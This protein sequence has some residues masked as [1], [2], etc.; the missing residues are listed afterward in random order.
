[1]VRDP[2]YDILFEP[3]KI[4]PVTARNRFYQVPHCNG[5]GRAYPSSMAAMR[6]TK[7]EGGWAV[8]CTEEMEI[9]P[10]ADHSPWS[11]G[12]L[13]DE[14]DIPVHARMCEAIH[15]FGSL[16]GAELNYA[17]LMSANRYS[18]MV[19]MGPSHMPVATHDPLQVRAMDKSDIADMRRWHRTAALRAQ[20]AGFDLVYVYIGHQLSVMSHF[21]SPYRN[22]RSDEYGGSLENRARLFREVLAD[23]RDAVGDTMAVAVRFAVDELMGDVG[24]TSQAEGRELIEMVA[25]DPDLWDVNI[26]GWE[27]DSATSRFKPSGFQND[28][29]RFVKQVTTKPVVGV[30]RHTS[31]DAM[32]SLVKSGVV[33]FIGAARPS[34]ADP[35]L[36]KKIEEGRIEDIRECIGCNI[37]VSGDHSFVPIRCTQNPTMGEEWR[38]GW[39]PE[40]IARRHADQSV[41]VVGAG[42]AGLEAARALGQRGYEVTLA[43]RGSAAG[44]RLVDERRLPGLAEWGRVVDHRT[45]RISQ[46]PNVRLYLESD[47]TPEMVDELDPDHV[48]LATG[49]K[50]VATGVGRENPTGI[51]IAD[52]ARVLT[53]DD[54]MGG[55]APE[56]PVIVFDDDHFYLGGLVAEKL[57]EDGHQVALVTP[58]AEVSAWTH[59][60]L[61]QHVIQARLIR[62]G[63]EVIVTHNLSAVH[64][65]QVTL[66]CGYTGREIT[67]DCDAVVL[68]TMRTPEDA[69]YH[70][71]K[72]TRPGVIR[73]GDGLAPSTIAAAVHAGHKAARDLGEE[74]NPDT[75]PFRRELL[76]LSD[77]FP[78]GY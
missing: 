1:M 58:A 64:A 45:W 34:I 56:G 15:E 77:D 17:G 66:A 62:M 72:G 29:I 11:G 25:E 44:G 8:V 5:M 13:W 9:H 32:V 60:T 19:P 6:R 50:W 74:I 55:A 47:V 37:C 48:I 40:R 76:E 36:P 52:A 51:K 38:R 75:V 2:R 23:T 65:G 42:P 12:R 16:A 59:N 71:L 3:V 30:G 26:S 28:Y 27:H 78:G 57:H 46:M 43:D 4:G 39:H 35:F 53:P 67:R 61:E 10:S 68:V 63:V 20:D 73:I 31:P 18:R 21:L 54:I 41:L 24:F 69:L 33:D 14:A 70:A 22:R 49:S 7:A